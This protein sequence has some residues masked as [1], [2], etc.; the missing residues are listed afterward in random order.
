MRAWVF[1][2]EKGWAFWVL[3]SRW[4]AARGFL[5]EVVDMAFKGQGAGNAC[6]EAQSEGSEDF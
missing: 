6:D 4:A 2:G 1:P 3:G 5:G